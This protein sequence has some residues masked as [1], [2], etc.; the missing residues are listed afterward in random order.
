MNPTGN[1]IEAE[2]LAK[3][4]RQRES[5]GDFN[6]VGDAGT[7]KGGY[8]FQA[9]TWKQYAK[10]VLGDENAQMTPENQNAVAYGKIKGWKDKGKNAAEIAAMWNAG[11]RIGD[12]WKTNKGKTE[13]NFV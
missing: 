4:I 9:G 1:D 10:E 7:S 5:G 8:Q 3:A 12:R 2:N 6:A 13:V 11:E